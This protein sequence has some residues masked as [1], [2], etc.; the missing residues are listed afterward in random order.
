MGT[1]TSKSVSAVVTIET[2]LHRLAELIIAK[3]PPSRCSSKQTAKSCLELIFYYF[4]GREEETESKQ[5]N[6][7]EKYQTLPCRQHSRLVGWPRP[8]FLGGGQRCWPE[9][10]L[11][12]SKWKTVWGQCEGLE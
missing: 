10:R 2:S 9:V 6:E 3:P 4:R 12:L 5:I 11:G 8:G 1:F 7:Q